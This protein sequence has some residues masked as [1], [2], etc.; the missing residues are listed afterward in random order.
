MNVLLG[1]SIVSAF[2]AGVAALFA[3]CCITVLLPSYLASIFRERYKVFLMTFIFFLGIL[4]VF[5][6]L[7][8]G[9]AALGQA[10][11]RYHTPIF[12]AGSVLLLVL[13]L[14]MLTGTHM[15]LPFKV[16]PKLR[17][18]NA[19]SVYL[20]GIFSGIA[21]TC[22]APVLAGVLALAALPGSIFWGGIYTL[23]YVLG[24]VS[25]LFILAIILDKS[26]ASGRL[27]EK[28]S[29]PVTYSLGF[30]KVTISLM[31]AVS[32]LMFVIMGFIT[33]YFAVTGKLISHA[34]YAPY[35][36]IYAAKATQAMSG[37]ISWI[38]SIGWVVIF[39]AIIAAIL[40][41][42]IRQWRSEEVKPTEDKTE[43]KVTSEKEVTKCH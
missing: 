35:I 14:S 31:E 10:F 43:E 28:F 20:L 29:A 26:N 5:L 25:P 15:K 3:P 7:G 6:P 36:N 17:N 27:Q 11:S 9:V 32:G 16:N 13:G 2:I 1:A 12:I 21:T 41:V 39:G 34:G 24:M 18:H 30:K 37:F 22:C 42:V 40:C 33:I 8:L 4:T 19:G 23:S 38:P